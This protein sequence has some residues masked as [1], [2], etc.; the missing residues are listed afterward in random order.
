MTARKISHAERQAERGLTATA[1]AT[2]DD[3]DGAPARSPS[4]IVHWIPTG[5]EK[6]LCG[7]GKSFE[8]AADA[9]VTCK[10]CARLMSNVEG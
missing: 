9:L 3:G 4:G 6:P 5:S 10:D 2:A 8:L 7:R 1:T